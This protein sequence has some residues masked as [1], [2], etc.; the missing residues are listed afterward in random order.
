MNSARCRRVENALVVLNVALHHQVAKIRRAHVRVGDQRRPGS[1]HRPSRC[2]APLPPRPP[3]T[4]HAAAA[5][6]ITSI[7]DMRHAS[8]PMISNL[9]MP[10]CVRA[11]A[12]AR[13]S[14]HQVDVR[15]Q[16]PRQRHAAI[17]RTASGCRIAPA[18]GPTHAMIR[19]HQHVVIG[20]VQFGPPI[21]RSRPA[22]ARPTCR[23][24]RA[25]APSAN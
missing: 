11:C 12:S 21:G 4:S 3:R 17:I 1:L 8:R 6:S 24:R 16:A 18:A 9:S 14:S 13:S 5:P 15:S 7:C 10:A 22:S 2:P 25:P 20:R 19:Q 23:P